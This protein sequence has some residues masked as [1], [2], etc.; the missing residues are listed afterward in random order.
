MQTHDKQEDAILMQWLKFS[1]CKSLFEMFCKF[2]SLTWFVEMCV[3]NTSVSL[4]GAGHQ[5]TSNSENF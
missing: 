2:F 4:E 1:R 5:P 3:H